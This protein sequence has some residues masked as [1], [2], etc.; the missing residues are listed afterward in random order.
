M[1]SSLFSVWVVINYFLVFYFY[2]FAP[3]YRSFC[4][5]FKHVHII[6]LV[7]F[8]EKNC[9]LICYFFSKDMYLNTVALKLMILTIFSLTTSFDVLNPNSK[10]Q[11]VQTYMVLSEKVGVDLTHCETLV[12]IHGAMWNLLELKWFWMLII[13]KTLI[14]MFMI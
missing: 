13:S 11:L 8:A 7:W 6:I 3:M 5:T 12:K 4:A 10:C 9:F 1:F 2:S 14:V